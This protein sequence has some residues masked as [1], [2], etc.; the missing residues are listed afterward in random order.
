MTINYLCYV[1]GIVNTSNWFSFS[2]P[3]PAA[4]RRS[5]STPLELTMVIGRLM[6]VLDSHACG[7]QALELT[8]LRGRQVLVLDY[9]RTDSS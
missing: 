1:K 8:M 4:G 5:F 6:F 3:V 7:R 2:T 9:A